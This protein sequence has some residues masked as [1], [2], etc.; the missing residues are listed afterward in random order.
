MYIRFYY[1]VTENGLEKREFVPKSQIAGRIIDEST[2]LGWKCDGKIK[3]I[4]EDMGFT[5]VGDIEGTRFKIIREIPAGEH[6]IHT[7]TCIYLETKRADNFEVLSL[8]LNREGQKNSIVK[9]NFINKNKSNLQWLMKDNPFIS[10]ISFLNGLMG[11]IIWDE[12]NFP[13]HL[14]EVIKNIIDLKTSY[15]N[16]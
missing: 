10:K 15:E 7:Q 12:I 6:H 1:K 9:S 16:L 13:S 8:D 5:I 3:Y 11:V 4:N 2:K 14:R